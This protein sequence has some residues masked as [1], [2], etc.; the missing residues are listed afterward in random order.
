MDVSSNKLK[1]LPDNLVKLSRL[2]ELDASDN[3]LKSL[4]YGFEDMTEI[5]SLDLSENQL[6]ELPEGMG[7]W[8]Q[9]TYLSIEDNPLQSQSL[10]KNIQKLTGAEKSRVSCLNSSCC[11]RYHVFLVSFMTS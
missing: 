8:T 11:P 10:P 5:T 9:L 6:T 4:P 7:D 2:I 3:K 1:H